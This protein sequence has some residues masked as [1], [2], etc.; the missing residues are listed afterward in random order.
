M[1][2]EETPW[3]S[4]G[5]LPEEITVCVCVCVC[6]CVFATQVKVHPLATKRRF[7]YTATPVRLLSDTPPYALSRNT[8]PDSLSLLHDTTCLHCD[9]TPTVDMGPAVR[10]V[11]P[12]VSLARQL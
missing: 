12:S 10:H 3:L 6:V 5:I 7:A 2:H 11:V 8:T 1:E 9:T 4:F